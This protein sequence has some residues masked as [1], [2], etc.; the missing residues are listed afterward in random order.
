VV[1]TVSATGYTGIA[2]VIVGGALTV[3][4]AAVV[5]RILRIRSSRKK[6]GAG[7]R[8]EGTR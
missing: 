7:G 4:L 5:L 6:R 3:M 8:R 1:L 2:A